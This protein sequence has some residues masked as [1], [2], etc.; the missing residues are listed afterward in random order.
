[1]G[2][3]NSYLCDFEAVIVLLK[4]FECYLIPYSS[5]EPLAYCTCGCDTFPAHVIS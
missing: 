2:F 5:I 3:L 4:F 1:M